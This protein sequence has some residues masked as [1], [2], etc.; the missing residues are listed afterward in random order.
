[1]SS[2]ELFS[3][4]NM[5]VVRKSY[6]CARRLPGKRESARSEDR[7]RSTVG[8]CAQLSEGQFEKPSS[9]LGQKPGPWDTSADLRS[10]STRS[11]SPRPMLPAA[12]T[13]SDIFVIQ[14][15]QQNVSLQSCLPF[16]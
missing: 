8:P 11:A 9:H 2:T 14:S 12:F 4:L 5:F 6:Q 10:V 16:D 3:F 7:S 13:Q 15:F 1:M